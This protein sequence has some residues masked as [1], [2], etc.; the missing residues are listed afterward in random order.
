M[1]HAA[2]TIS[3]LTAENESLRNMQR[4]FEMLNME[5]SSISAAA[6]R[7]QYLSAAREDPLRDIHLLGPFELFNGYNE[8]LDRVFSGRQV[9][10]PEVLYRYDGIVSLSSYIYPC[11]FSA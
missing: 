5:A 1:A 3:A 8:L 10:I 7:A 9:E 6:A 4:A 2:A 11:D